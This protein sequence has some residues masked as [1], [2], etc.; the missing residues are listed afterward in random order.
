MGMFKNKILKCITKR[1][2]LRTKGH[3]IKYLLYMHLFE[4]QESNVG[5]S[6]LVCDC[7]AIPFGQNTTYLNTTSS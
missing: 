7:K 3:N 5:K 1:Y 4:N 2:Y 6:N